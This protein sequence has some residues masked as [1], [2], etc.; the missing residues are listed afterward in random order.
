M[1]E[2]I[3]EVLADPR[4]HQAFGDFCSKTYSAENLLFWEAIQEYRKITE[5]VVRPLRAKAL[6]DKFVCPS[7]TFQVNLDD[8]TVQKILTALE[9]EE[10]APSLFDVCGWVG[11]LF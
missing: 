3:C 1:A 5:A 6:C 11:C 10:V 7:A 9:G 8:I 2:N 4:L